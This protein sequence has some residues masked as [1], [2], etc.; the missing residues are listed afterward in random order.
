M[1][2]DYF[3]VLG[4]SPGR[5]DAQKIAARFFDLREALLRQLRTSSGDADAR[6]RLDEL[7]LAFAALRDP[8]R[9][10]EYLQLHDAPTPDRTA[11]LRQFIAASLEYGLLRYSRRQAILAKAHELGFT[12]FQAQLMMAQEQFGDG[13]MPAWP[14]ERPQ[15]LN[16][17]HTRHWPRLAAT[18]LL[19]TGMFLLLVHWLGS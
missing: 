14:V 19:A 16:R 8:V 5:Y 11:E 17:P 7:H 15:R 18:G 2:L 4:L 10:A 1:A 12:D 6:R 3:A 9:Q 13:E